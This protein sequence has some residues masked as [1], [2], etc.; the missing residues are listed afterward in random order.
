VNPLYQQLTG[1]TMP[2]PVQAP[3]F[4]NPMQKMNYIMQAMTNPAA[5][6]RSRFPD[7][8]NNIS[9]DPNQILAYLQRTRGISNQQIQQLAGMYGGR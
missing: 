4:Q 9:N 6:V 7:I 2:Q 8:P 1:G 5:F 3:M